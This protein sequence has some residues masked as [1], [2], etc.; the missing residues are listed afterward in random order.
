MSSFGLDGWRSKCFL[1]S[2]LFF[3]GSGLRAAPE[4]LFP[5]YPIGFDTITYIAPV[6]KR[7]LVH[8]IDWLFAFQEAPLVYLLTYAICDL[9][10]VDVYIALK[11]VGALIYGVFGLSI[12]LFAHKGLKWSFG[13]SFVAVL[14]VYVQIA[15]LR[16]GWD[17]LR[18][19][20]G[21]AF[22]FSTLTFLRDGQ[23]VKGGAT[24]VLTALCNQ[25]S[26]VILFSALAFLLIRTRRAS[27]DRRK[28]LPVLLPAA[29]LFVA[30]LY[31]VL[32]LNAPPRP[33]VLSLLRTRTDFP[34]YL[35]VYGGYASFLLEFWSLFFFL[36]WPVLPFVAF[37]LRRSL[38]LESVLIPSTLYSFSPIIFPWVGVPQWWRWMLMLAF[39]LS[40][41]GADGLD[42]IW[43]W[44][45]H[46]SSKTW[47]SSINFKRTLGLYWIAILL[48]YGTMA[49]LYVSAPA[50]HPYSLFVNP[51]VNAYVPATMLSSSIKPRDF[52]ATVNCLRW[53]DS[54]MDDSSCLIVE[55]RFFG[56]A[57]MIL[58]E[59]KWIVVYP[60]QSASYQAALSLALKK[61]FHTIYF[62][63]LSN[64]D[65]QNFKEVLS[66]D[67]IAVYYYNKGSMQ[68]YS[69]S[70]L[71]EMLNRT[72]AEPCDR[73]C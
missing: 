24:A 56:W 11:A 7:W 27:L 8:G 68:P 67:N 36:Y 20:L 28:I 59:D 41:Y 42:R 13:K 32:F 49:T 5:S 15:C 21:M 48:V 38:L 57:Q 71:A 18:T 70:S 35:E 65:I 19:L 23:Y 39:P 47:P 16:V 58:R 51:R 29:I 33:S 60:T 34:N 50:E 44:L 45:T 43:V 9:T 17:L 40:L 10:E 55:E 14:F 1:Y 73:S 62:L 52:A 3:L 72:L 30:S 54:Q 53:L 64:R 12:L 31:L 61:G 6:V 37:G 66:M 2:L 22:V 26:S 4:L 69:S 63:W 46:R 25:F